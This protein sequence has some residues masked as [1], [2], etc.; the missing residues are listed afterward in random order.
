MSDLK[1]RPTDEELMAYA[2]GECSPAAAAVIE[3]ALETDPEVAD[4]LA[5]FMGTRDLSAEAF[6]LAPVPA[7]LQASVEALIARHTEAAAPATPA[8]AP[9]AADAPADNVV[10]FRPRAATKPTQSTWFMAM[11]ASVLGVAFGLGAFFAMGEF[12]GDRGGG[13]PG[14]GVQQLASLPLGELFAL[15]S[16]E[17]RPVDGGTARMV[18]AFRD[19]SGNLCREFEVTRGDR[20]Q[21][22][23]CRQDGA[24]SVNFAVATAAPTGG[25]VPASGAEALDAY[26]TQ[27]EAAPPLSAEEERAALAGQ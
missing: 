7:S 22:V 26:L 15:P 17:A 5:I 4:R 20:V 10:A 21:G 13:A 14:A 27:I 3:A 8:P 16:G 19:G 23:A 11:A 25:Y 9:P 24:W 2:D 12:A 18:A 1:G 6:P